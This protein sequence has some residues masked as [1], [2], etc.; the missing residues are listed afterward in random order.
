MKPLVFA[1]LLSSILL[2]TTSCERVTRYQLRG[3]Y[4]RVGEPQPLA[5]NEFEV[6]DTKFLVVM[7][8]A[9][10]VALDYEVEGDNL[11]LGSAPSQILFTREGQGYLRQEGALGFEGRF[12]KLR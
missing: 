11:Y 2:L 6:T 10:R 5:V 3:T 8:L 9:G 1:A 7:P 4:Y 12:V